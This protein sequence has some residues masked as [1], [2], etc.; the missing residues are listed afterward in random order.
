MPKV[1]TRDTATILSLD[2]ESVLT[3]AEVA[4]LLGMTVQGVRQ[5]RVRGRLSF[6]Q[7]GKRYFTTAGALRA[8]TDGQ[9]QPVIPVPEITTIEDLL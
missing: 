6:Q 1:C 2:P 3:T 9:P 5:L 7:Q 4:R 8:Y